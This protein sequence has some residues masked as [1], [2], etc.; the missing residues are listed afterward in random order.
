MTALPKD[1][2]PVLEPFSKVF[3]Q[4]RTW[5]LAQFLLFGLVLLKGGRTV[6][7]ILRFMGIKGQKK[8]DK[9]HKLIN[10]AKW[11]LKKASSITLNEI[12]ANIP[13]GET[14]YIAADEHLERRRG[15]N[16]TA[17]GCYRDAVL[18]TKRC[19]V[20]SFGLKWLTVMVLMKFSWSEKT[21]ALPFLTILTRSRESDLKSGNPHKTSTDWMCQLTMQ[22]KRWLPQR[23]IVITTDGGLASSEYG[24]TCLRLGIHWVTRL[25]FNARLYDFAQEKTGRGRPPIRG[26]RLLSPKEMHEN[27]DVIWQ[28][29]TVKWYGIEERRIN[30]LTFTCLR[31]TETTHPLPVRIVCL[32]DPKGEFEPITLMG[33]SKDFSLTAKEMIESSISRWNQEVT[34]REVREHLGVETQ[35]QWSDNAIKRCT[36]I[37]FTLYT[38]ILLMA[39]RLNVSQPL[40]PVEAAWYKKRYVTFSDALIAVRKV[41]WSKGDFNLVH[42]LSPPIENGQIKDLGPFWDYM[43]EVI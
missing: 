5:I 14:I 13:T 31:H 21:F 32:R 11:D 39:N 12:I 18:S 23:R 7:R 9:Y 3:S 19:K 41:L 36:P 2:L 28:E 37:L 33:V 4:K 34:H 8:F 38:L 26:N 25:Q 40:K 6:C 27:T 29:M 16:I 15:S 1:I 43:A 30:Y 10:R 24:W 20:K 42:N 35:R 17:I 22:I